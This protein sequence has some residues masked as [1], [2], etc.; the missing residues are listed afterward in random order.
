V[1]SLRGTGGLSSDAEL[2]AGRLCDELAPLRMLSLKECC[3]SLR[4]A[5]PL[6]SVD[7]DL[8]PGGLIIW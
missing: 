7:V 2:V 6:S 8:V 5:G 1:S 3:V 4:P